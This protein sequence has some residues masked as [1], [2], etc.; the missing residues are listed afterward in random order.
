M[1]SSR[2][3]LDSLND[4]RQR[5]PASSLED[6]RHTIAALEERLR[7]NDDANTPDAA[8]TEEPL[9]RRSQRL[10]G[11]EPRPM[12]LRQEEAEATLSASQ[13]DA[14]RAELREQLAA[15]LKDEFDGLRQEIGRSLAE[16]QPAS[17]HT[18]TL[19]A[20]LEQLSQS[21][22][23][24]AVKGEAS[25]V[26]HLR[27][28]L[29]AL[30][31]A[32]NQLARE[33]TVRSMDERW[34]AFDRRFAEI[35]QRIPADHAIGAMSEH[36]TRIGDAIAHLPQ[37][38][39]VRSLEENVHALA[40]AIDH[41][42]RQID[43]APQ[44]QF[45]LIEERLDEI[46]RAI[47]AATAVYS[48]PPSSDQMERI[49]ARIASLAQQI[50]EIVQDRAGD[51]LAEKI[52]ILAKSVDAIAARAELPQDA[53]DQLAD[54]LAA[55][56]ERLD[57]V[58]GE[59][60]ID[61]IERRFAE[62]LA[63]LDERQAEV[64]A[65]EDGRF[66]DLGSRLDE[67]SRRME[68]W[69]REGGSNDTAILDQ[70]DRRFVELS[71]YVA[72]NGGEAVAGRMIEALDH[73]LEAISNRLDETAGLPRHD[74]ELI[75]SLETQLA[76]LT[77]HLSRA[78]LGTQAL[79]AIK[80][81]L[82]GIEQSIA[83]QRDTLIEAAR[84]AA[85]QA[86]Q[87][88][89]ETRGEADNAAALAEELRGLEALAR[90]SDEKNTRTFE[91]IHDTLL[92][93]V[94]RLAALEPTRT[95]SEDGTGTFARSR[96]ESAPSIEPDEEDEAEAAAFEM[97]AAASHSMPR[98]RTP[99]EAAAAAASA[100]VEEEHPHREERG[101]SLIGG[102]SRML[103]GRKSG[104]AAANEAQEPVFD[105]SDEPTEALPEES[106][107]SL[108]ASPEPSIADTPLEP[109]SGAPDINA[110]MRRVRS[111]RA[112]SDTSQDPVAAR[113]DFIAAARRAAQ[114]AA[115]EAETLK[116]DTA[117][118]SATRKFGPL[119]L[120]R[121]KR[122]PILMAATAI[123]L[124]LAGLQAGKVFLE[125]DAQETAQPQVPATP[126]VAEAQGIADTDDAAGAAERTEAPAAEAPSQQA[127]ASSADE[128]DTAIE[129][130][131]L[132]APDA[133]KADI[134]TEPSPS[135]SAATGADEAT[136]SRT[137]PEAATAAPSHDPA[138]V[139]AG[140]AA[141]RK[142]ADGGDP[143]A[144]FEI[145]RRYDDG[146][147]LAADAAKAAMWYERAAE[148]G[149]AP[150]QY[151]IGNA[152]EKGLGVERDTEKAK[153]W[154]RRAADQGNASAMHNLAVL[155]AMGADGSTD[156]ETAARWFL[157]AAERGVKDSQFNMAILSAKG[158]GVPQSLEESYK[159]FALVAMTGDK[160]AEAKRDEVAKALR[161][162]QLER[163]RAAA[164]LWQAKPLDKS[165]NV[166]DIPD[167]W[168]TDGAP[169]AGIDRKRAVSNVQAILN[170]TGYDAG[171]ADGII[172]QKTRDAIA[173]FQKAHGMAQTG[174]V[175]PTFV[176][177]LLKAR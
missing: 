31:G 175:D 18:D 59:A 102:L 156:N 128:R 3:Y 4:G 103:P 50:E 121:A 134:T 148:I 16:M 25:S 144:I 160:D 38:Q 131:A 152:Y 64:T 74:A 154:Y 22:Q 170:E 158:V 51:E 39:M 166:V 167:E 52:A 112:R 13:L 17:P 117:K 153:Q 95:E 88:F 94:E 68:N 46:S 173:A 36:L 57:A 79:D 130:A 133:D 141:L 87:S 6:L 75:R 98:P 168:R 176:K 91:A 162:E 149:L 48:Q 80:P 135:P 155:H 116:Q 146:R 132:P 83:G 125:D 110:I 164:E 70:I 10:I 54:Q 138:P 78:P 19:N 113:A 151:R 97:E 105:G 42:S 9:S 114:A 60:M 122:K 72:Q 104:P 137:A 28:D 143:R 99:Q 124:A 126:T 145:G 30:R 15:G 23:S 7:M 29:D 90:R 139:E 49:E 127:E 101:R 100:A 66:E 140:P 93:V 169:T 109:G 43:H 61:R 85:L 73:R 1:N 147:G 171:P 56:R 45:E 159:W 150:A 107:P 76:D 123:A 63:Y 165:A 55:I 20:E 27:H 177:A 106:E 174:N 11:G 67:L 81:Q 5:R 115:A 84:Q 21:I 8:E 58:D 26:E 40:T 71:D 47:A 92:Q 37:S 24:L 12:E 129:T 69:P 44:Q 82:A 41:F 77:A 14:M 172:G 62:V 118:G 120:L 32:M 108:D 2:S 34:D 157:N 35:E 96:I 142:A 111:E 163:A 53:L 86:V 119:E 161:P 65:R 89:G 33:E 136:K